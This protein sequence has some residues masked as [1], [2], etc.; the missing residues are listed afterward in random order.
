MAN[1]R[2]GFCGFCGRGNPDPEDCEHEVDVVFTY[3][4]PCHQECE[5][6]GYVF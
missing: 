5:K 2:E 1:E 3:G 6:C 4:E